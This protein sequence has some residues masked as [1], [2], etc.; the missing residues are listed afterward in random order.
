MLQF[1]RGGSATNIPCEFDGQIWYAVVNEMVSSSARNDANRGIVRERST[2]GE[3]SHWTD[4]SGSVCL[5][6][7]SC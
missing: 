3:L 7:L 2:R 5:Y 4:C 6:C 1:K